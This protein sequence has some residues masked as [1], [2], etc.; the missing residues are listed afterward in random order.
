MRF[1]SGT[2]FPGFFEGFL[3]HGIVRRAVTEQK[4]NILAHD[5]RAFT[6]DKHCIV[7]DR[8]YG[9]SAGMVLKPE[10]IFRAR[11]AT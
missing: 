3:N 7:D 1:D 4:V 10:P 6:S 2:I 5:I 11:P 8:P 9:G